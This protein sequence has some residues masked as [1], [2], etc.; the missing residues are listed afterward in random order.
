MQKHLLFILI[1]YAL[2]ACNSQTNNRAA[3]TPA[4]DTAAPSATDSSAATKTCYAY[5]HNKDTIV[6]SITATGNQ[7]TGHLLY[8]LK[9]R[10][11]NDGTLQGTI[12]G[13]TLLANYHFASEGMLSL[14]Q[15][16]F[17]KQQDSLREGFGELVLKDTAYVFKNPHA[18]QFKGFVLA[19]VACE[20]MA[21][22]T[23]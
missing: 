8:Q 14:R 17:L 21:A 3:A 12:S 20:Q 10:D 15:V 22:A 5:M 7:F 16:A 9:E 23:K 11:R 19:P 1:A 18:L 2:A 6:L 4:Q 13:D